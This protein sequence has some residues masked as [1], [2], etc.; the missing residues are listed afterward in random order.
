[1]S[2]DY[3]PGD[4]YFTE[5]FRVSKEQII[6]GGNYF[7][8]PPNRCFLIWEKTNIPENF[9]M[10][11]AEYA[12]CSMNSNAKIIKL[13]SAG[14]AGRFHPTQKPVALYRWIFEKYAKPGFKIL[15]THL[16]S[17]SSRIAAYDAGLDFVGF[18]LDKDYFQMEEKRFEE[19]AAQ[20]N[21]F[22]TPV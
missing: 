20:M 16:G 8:L 1:M 14:I 15:D 9:S 4:D 21:L 11:M 13:S 6:W 7:K 22:I 5:L 2:W 17:G 3:A 12:W 10:A 19:H 18:E